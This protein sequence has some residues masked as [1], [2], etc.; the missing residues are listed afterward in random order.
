MGTTTVFSSI[1]F[2]W[3]GIAREMDGFLDPSLPG[4][5]HP[6]GTDQLG[7]LPRPIHSVAALFTTSASPHSVSPEKP[8]IDK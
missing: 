6:T 3:E 8:S 4:I 7:A 2:S 5:G 1:W